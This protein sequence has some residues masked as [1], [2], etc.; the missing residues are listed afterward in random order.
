MKKFIIN[1]I[2]FILAVSITNA[3]TNYLNVENSS[4]DGLTINVI[5]IPAISFTSITD[6]TGTLYSTINF[7]GTTEMEQYKPNL[8]I[9]SSMILI[10]N[11]STVSFQIDTGFSEIY[12]NIL[13]RPQAALLS[14][15]DSN[16]PF[17]K[18]EVIYFTDSLFPGTF[19]SLDF[20]GKMHGQECAV[21]RIYPFQHNP[22]KKQLRVY[23]H[24]SVSLI[25]NG[26][27]EL[28]L[29]RFYS[30]NFDDLLR[31]TAI[32]AYE[33]LPPKDSI[34]AKI[35]QIPKS[36][37]SY[38]FII[39]T[40]DD[41]IVD[42]ETLAAW[43]NSIGISTIVIT[44]SDIASY[45]HTL[46]PSGTSDVELETKR[47][48]IKNY[49]N[50][51]VQN[52]NPVPSYL[53]FIG[54]SYDIPP[55]LI[56]IAF[57]SDSY[58]NCSYSTK[59]IPGT[60]DAFI[61]PTD[62]FY[63]DFNFVQGSN[64][65]YFPDMVYGRLPVDKYKLDESTDNFIESHEAKN[66]VNK[67]ISYERKDYPEEFYKNVTLASEFIDRD[68]YD[69]INC[70]SNDGYEDA[71][72]VKTCEDVANYL[73]N[74]FNI[75][76]IYSW[77]PCAFNYAYPTKWTK[78]QDFIFENDISGDPIPSSV[79]ST[80]LELHCDDDYDI[81]QK[82]L[83]Y[84]NKNNGSSLLLYRGHGG[85]NKWIGPH[86]EFD[87]VFNSFDPIDLSNINPPIIWSIAC[88]TGY[89]AGDITC[90]EVDPSI[91]Y[92]DRKQ[93][94]CFAETWLDNGWAVG[95]IAST[96][97]SKTLYNDRM[98]WG[99]MD[100]VW[101][102]FIESNSGSYRTDY[103]PYYSLGD[104]LNY[105]MNYIRHCFTSMGDV[106]YFIEKYHCLGDPTMRIIPYPCKQELTLQNI[107]V[108]NTRPA[109]ISNNKITVAGNDIN[110]N[111]TYFNI[112]AGGNSTMQ[113]GSSIIL[114]PGFHAKYG[115]YYHAYIVPCE[116]TDPLILKNDYISNA[117]DETETIKK[118]ISRIDS[119]VVITVYPNPSNGCFEINLMPYN[120]TNSSI[121]IYDNFGK[122]VFTNYT[123][124]FPYNVNL[125]K[126]K[127]GL[128]FIKVTTG[129]DIK[130]KKIIIK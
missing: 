27:K 64:G 44:T 109:D 89:F 83:Y 30:K 25:F 84:L 75:N 56:D 34:E 45:Y 110:S 12:N 9:F 41:F 67:I 63:A 7:E 24:L 103:T 81:S 2:G 50:D 98:V 13:I 60:P 114:K 15:N 82:Y 33:I 121:E 101:P 35:N 52:S 104:I 97:E 26:T 105:S 72:Y 62:L 128:Y 76:K 39:I 20:K 71:R 79:Q 74:N 86:L 22:V 107:T 46:Y 61:I 69:G 48:L 53:L 65:D 87:P 59:T 102:D 66:L 6:S 111:S 32:N 119:I 99:M 96:R 80:I 95:V 17:K 112:E 124:S 5:N 90:S 78:T 91:L 43:K 49:I 106:N 51:V 8:P 3:Q 31:S 117:G 77:K 92:W 14:D 94:D 70:L 28:L 126:I 19:A 1:I 113:A 115:S 68:G 100:A 93:Y 108:N 10:P 55:W 47:E 88:S 29:E 127:P 4:S 125:L 18:D 16:D 85:Q 40:H 58:N 122:N 116:E 36:C 54:D 123:N 11:G 23:P 37:N 118:E 21:L 42:A 38:D 129:N 130:T 73:K 57:D 120:N